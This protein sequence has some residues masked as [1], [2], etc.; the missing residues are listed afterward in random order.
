MR[1]NK[2]FMSRYGKYMNRDKEVE[3]VKPE[4]ELVKQKVIIPITDAFLECRDC[5]RKVKKNRKNDM[6]D[7]CPPCF[8]DEPFFV[9]GKCLIALNSL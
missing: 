5:K 4:V 3:L 2:E 9:R 1:M 7:I 8:F 6:Y